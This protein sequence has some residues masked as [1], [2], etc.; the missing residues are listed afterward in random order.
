MSQITE[1]NGRTLLDNSLVL[2]ISEMGQGHHTHNNI[3]V[4]LIGSLGCALA[5]NRHLQR[6]GSTTGDL[7][8]SV[9]RLFGLPATSFGYNGASGL[10]H[11]GLSGVA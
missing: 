6:S 8:T 1:P 3:P 10:N 5:G 9:L 4:V 2:W 11:G 7:F